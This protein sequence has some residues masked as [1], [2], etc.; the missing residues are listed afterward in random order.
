MVPL[1]LK[2]TSLSRRFP[3]YKTPNPAL[4][5]GCIAHMSTFPVFYN[6]LVYISSHPLV[7]A[8][9]P[10]SITLQIKKQQ[11]VVFWM[12]HW[13]PSIAI[14]PRL[15]L[16]I[17]PDRLVSWTCVDEVNL[18]TRRAVPVC[19]PPFVVMCHTPARTH[20]QLIWPATDWASRA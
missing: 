3:P 5:A 8:E 16:C 9:V 11:S 20:C 15:A 12:M 6:A 14:C 18:G 7:E 17:P 19:P 13:P 2:C 10:H 1:P 4:E